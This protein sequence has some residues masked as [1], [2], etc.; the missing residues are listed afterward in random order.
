MFVVNILLISV[1]L[2]ESVFMSYLFYL[3]G[4]WI[5][6]ACAVVLLPLC[7]KLGVDTYRLKTGVT[8]TFFKG[9]R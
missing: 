3:G 6:G 2:V 1:G 8:P 7:A 5:T 4:G 9:K